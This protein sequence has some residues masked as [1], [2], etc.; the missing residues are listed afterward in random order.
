VHA[1]THPPVNV[2]FLKIPQGN[3]TALLAHT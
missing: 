3:L 2:S 1:Q